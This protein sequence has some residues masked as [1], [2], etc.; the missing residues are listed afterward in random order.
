MGPPLFF[1]A[2]RKNGPRNRKWTFCVEMDGSKR[3]EKIQ[4]ISES[5]GK[6]VRKAGI[7]PPEPEGFVEKLQKYGFSGILP[8]NPNRKAGELEICA[9]Y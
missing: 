6:M 3:T 9:C 4:I 7:F 5:D 8:G 1:A 2:E